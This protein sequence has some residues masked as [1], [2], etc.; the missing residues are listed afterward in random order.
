LWFRRSAQRRRLAPVDV[1]GPR[2]PGRLPGSIPARS[3]RRSG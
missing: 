2:C 1:P 3:E